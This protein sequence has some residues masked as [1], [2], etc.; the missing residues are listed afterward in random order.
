MKT[1]I[2]RKAGGSVMLAVP[3]AL[4]DALDLSAGSSVDLALDAGRLVI[5]PKTRPRYS[6][7]ELLARYDSSSII[8]SESEED[9]LWDGMKPVGR[10]LL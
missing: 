9:R 1:A 2:L 5:E 7:E 10:E 4:L 8:I 6:L 3:P